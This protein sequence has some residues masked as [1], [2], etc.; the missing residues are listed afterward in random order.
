M[1]I[2]EYVEG[3]AMLV[4]IVGGIWIVGVMILMV[5]VFPGYGAHNPVLICW[6]EF[7]SELSFALELRR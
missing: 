1:T 2:R 5:I 6:A 7:P 3:R 4:R